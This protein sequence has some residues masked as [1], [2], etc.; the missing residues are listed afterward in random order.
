MSLV[1]RVIEGAVMPVFPFDCIELSRRFE[2]P[3]WTSASLRVR[4]C[5]SAWLCLGAGSELNELSQGYCLGSS[6]RYFDTQC[7]HASWERASCFNVRQPETGQFKWQ[8]AGCRIEIL[9]T[10]RFF[11]RLSAFLPVCHPIFKTLLRT[12]TLSLHNWMM[13]LLLTPV[14]FQS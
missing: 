13:G 7:D 4:T 3:S 12:L 2:D 8:P 14:L 10:G 6:C 11:A 9:T 5:P 1:R